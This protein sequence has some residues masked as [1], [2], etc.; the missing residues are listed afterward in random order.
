MQFENAKLTAKLTEELNKLKIDN[1]D[2]K[3]NIQT[4]QTISATQPLTSLSNIN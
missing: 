4:T 1:I 3:Q 2:T